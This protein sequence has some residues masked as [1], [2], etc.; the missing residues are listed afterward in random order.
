MRHSPTFL[1][2]ALCAFAASAALAQTTNSTSAPASIASRLPGSLSFSYDA[3]HNQIVTTGLP[4]KPSV[5]SNLL[6]PTTGTLVVTVNINVASQFP[7]GTAFAC[8]VVAL[9]GEI[10]TTHG[11]VDGAL[12]T[13]NGVGV[14]TGPGMAACTLKIPYS[15]VLVPDPVATSGIIVAVGVAAVSS[16]DDSSFVYRSTLQLGG[17]ESLPPNG[18]TSKFVLDVTL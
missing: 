9:G 5:K 10:D 4:L 16:H 18:S 3:Q 1:A 8:S 14:P 13:A 7:H 2:A 17:I 12:E 15:W 11:V 6:T